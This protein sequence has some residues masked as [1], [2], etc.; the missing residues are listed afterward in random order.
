M[1]G[2]K[3]DPAQQQRFYELKR[4]DAHR[5]H[6]RNDDFH[7]YVNKQVVKTG[8]SALRMAM[9]INGGAAVSLLTFIGQL[10]R[11]QRAAMADTLVWFAAGVLL[12]VVA[13]ATSYFTDFFLAALTSSRQKTWEPPYLVDTPVTKRNRR[14]N[15]LFHIITIATAVASLGTFIVGV[16]VVRGALAHMS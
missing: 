6:D 8:Q 16:L 5:A 14:L 3:L 13:I 15:I 1:P 4:E 7:T 2:Q 11:E 10:A 9:L 12:A